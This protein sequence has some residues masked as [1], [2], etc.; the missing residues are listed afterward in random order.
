MSGQEVPSLSG[1]Q[2]SRFVGRIAW[3]PLP[4]GRL[5]ELIEPFGFIDSAG[6]SWPVPSGA[7]VDGASIPQALW[8]VIGSPF[9]GK[10]RDAS[11]VHDYY[12]D[13]RARPWPSV[14]R[15]FYDAMIV[16]GVSVSRAKLMYAAVYFAGPRWSQ[17]TEHNNN[18]NKPPLSDYRHFKVTRSAFARDTMLAID[19]DGRTVNDFMQSDE[20]VFKG[21]EAHLQLSSFDELINKYIP[22]PEE[23]ASALDGSTSVIDAKA[24]KRTIVDLKGVDL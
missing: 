16:S 18:L 2:E 19:L 5:M 21:E 15:V 6:Q 24:L 10:Y 13:I 4:D 12:C 9:T 1:P 22:S 11:V 14:H 20:S 23:I 8:S 17:A 7:Q 3:T